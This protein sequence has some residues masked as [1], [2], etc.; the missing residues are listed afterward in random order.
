MKSE[1]FVIV[2][3]ISTSYLL[4]IAESC[5]S[6]SHYCIIYVI[7]IQNNQSAQFLVMFYSFHYLLL[8]YLF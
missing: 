5:Y 4:W 8:I 6:N 7:V 3:V 2:V 1:I